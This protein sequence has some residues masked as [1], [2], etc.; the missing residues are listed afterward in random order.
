MKIKRTLAL[1][2]SL[3]ASPLLRSA[4]RASPEAL[5]MGAPAL[6]IIALSFVLAGFCI[7]S[8]SVCQA[9]GNPIYSLVVSV[10]RQLVVLL[11][12][13]WLLSQTGN[14]TLVWLAFPIAELM[15]LTLSAIFLRK[16]LRMAERAMTQSAS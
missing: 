10:C 15:S 4:F 11:P 14:L 2:L 7:I 9:I 6:R 8:M 1:L 5:A 12:V 13:A 3:L 16:T